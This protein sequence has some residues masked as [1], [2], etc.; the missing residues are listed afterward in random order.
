[1]KISYSLLKI[2]AIIFGIFTLLWMTYDFISNKK[3]INKNYV[4]ANEAFLKKNYNQALKYYNQ[5][6]SDNPENIYYLEGKARTFFKIGYL[7]NAEK[8]FLKVIKRDETFVA[9]IANLGILY[10]YKGEYKKALKYYKLAINKQSKVTEGMPFL[11]RFFNNIH[12]KPA[13]VKSRSDYLETELNSGK[14]ELNL[15]N[16]EIDKQQPDFQM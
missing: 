16:I 12:F 14:K 3:N 7:N 13:S 15:R 11:K 4:K 5:A 9:A 6:L 1:M 10:D 2:I 8:L